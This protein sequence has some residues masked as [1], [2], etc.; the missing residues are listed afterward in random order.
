MTNAIRT[1]DEMLAGLPGFA[2]ESRFHEFA[3]LRLAHLDEGEGPPVW[4]MHGEPT[5]SYL[6][7]KVFPPVVAAGFR[8]IVPDLP[9]F[10]RSDK[11][12]EIDWFTYDRHVAA[13]AA[14]LDELDL[15]GAT[16]VVHDWGGPIGLRLAVEHRERF[17]RLVI[18][19]TGLATG[20]S[21][22]SDLWLAFRDFV[23]ASE[24]LPIGALVR[25]GCHTDPGEDVLAA[26]D[27]PYVNAEAKAGPRAFPDLVPTD[28]E[29]PDAVLNRE[30]IAALRD[31]GRPAL[32]LWGANDPVLSVGLG[33]AFTAAI[34]RDAPEVL[35]DAGH[36]LQEDRGEDIGRR[37]AEWLTS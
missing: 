30:L 3:G 20:Q 21:P 19:D 2:Y 9:G 11:P 18:L 31:D 25:A 36:F 8:A 24:D 28:P 22:P 13:M 26:Y 7:R 6:W 4:F 17:D 33:R 1:P 16:M 35:E 15:R 12:T 37:I 29:H 27:A 5:W 14:L 34:G 32:A 23:R 10:G